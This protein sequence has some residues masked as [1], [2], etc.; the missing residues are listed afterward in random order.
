MNWNQ[1][2]LKRMKDHGVDPLQIDR[3]IE[4]FKQGTKPV[5][6]ARA[7]TS[8][9]GIQQLSEEA[10]TE[11][12]CLFDDSAPTLSISKFVPASGAASR[13][14]KHLH[15]WKKDPLAPLV[16]E[17]L[18]GFD[19]FAFAMDL[20]QKGGFSQELNVQDLPN[21][22]NL[23]F[24]ETAFNFSNKP[25]G[26]VPF[27]KKGEHLITPFEEHLEEAVAYAKGKDE[28]CRL[29]FTVAPSYRDEIATLV[30]ERKQAIE[31]REG[32][33]I[34]VE[35]SEQDPSTDTIA[36][37]EN[38]D[39]YRT[40]IGDF[41]FRPGGHGA[42]IHNLNTVNSDLIFIKNIDNVVSESKRSDTISYK[43]VI[44]G[45]ALKLMKEIHHLVD[46]LHTSTDETI[47]ED[48]TEFVRH[49]FSVSGTGELQFSREELLK[50]L[51]KPLRVCGMVKNEGEPG[52]GPFW[53][54]SEDGEVSTQIIEKAQIN[55]AD[56]T[57]VKIVE[58]A[59]HFNPVDLVCAVK[60]FNGE[61]FDLNKFVNPAAAFIA[62]KSIGD[63]A[64]KALELPGLWNGA[65]ED[66]NTVFVEVPLSTFNPV[67][68]VN[69]LLR[70][71]HQG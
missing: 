29:H 18:Q 14:F 12:V 11:L 48:A 61:K 3:Q 42:L 67:K 60:D 69:D 47:E 2:D 25:K 71:A 52:G 64:I 19:G 9:D 68:T 46:R 53:T 35:Y 4:L 1:E 70:P 45:L 28:K 65:M 66:W 57:Q 41:L 54:F 49:W 6:L 56:E 59:T 20:R 38:N 26:L 63:V 5:V 24:D 62:D 7:C 43:K 33:L 27:H 23:M 21:I 13:M 17:F 22:L 50:K 37:F 55:L 44:G 16:Q 8:G 30:E 36:V 51:N 40:E 39:P 31:E 32:V 34:E 15:Q 58:H 10:K